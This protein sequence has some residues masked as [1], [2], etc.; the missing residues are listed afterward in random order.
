M[1]ENNFLGFALV[2]PEESRILDWD[3][4][5]DDLDMLYEDFNMGSNYC[6]LQFWSYPAE[7]ESLSAL[8]FYFFDRPL[9]GPQRNKRRVR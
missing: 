3:L 2:N 1:N 7:I 8:H 9:H 5:A 4:S 6:K